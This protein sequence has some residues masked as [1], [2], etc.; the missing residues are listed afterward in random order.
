[1][2]SFL[3]PREIRKD[4]AIIYW[5]ARTAD[6]LADEGD[7]SEEERLESLNKFENRLTNSLNGEY[8]DEFDFALAETVNSRKLSREN[9][10]SLLK[11]FKQDVVKKRYASFS[12]VKE[13]C[14]NSANPVGRL[15]LE[16]FDIRNEEASQYSDNICTAL[17]L[18]N[19][20]QDVKI[21]YKK[22]RIYFPI[23]E[24]GKF[25]V[26]EN[27]FR[28]SENTFNLQQ[29][30]EFNVSRTR[31]LFHSGRQLFKHLS[32]RLRVEIT[33][34]VFG[35]EAILDK[36]EKNNYYVMDKIPKLN[37]LDFIRLFLNTI[38]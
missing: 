3:I 23:D 29:L 13:Y 9:F 20:Y 5:F 18:T 25:G 12:E 31:E 2:I 15:I 10:Y 24:M 19:F 16:L 32:G 36:I 35:G 37:K 34:T 38:F 14:R 28:M 33:W 7:F 4:V 30:V 17:Q 8:E 22:G 27:M 26:T 21:D 1:V 6:D 11:A